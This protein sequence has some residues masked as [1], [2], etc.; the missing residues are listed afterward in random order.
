MVLN[1]DSFC[2]IN[3][4]ELFNFHFTKSSFLT[5][6]VVSR[7]SNE[8]YGNLLIDDSFEVIGYKEKQEKMENLYTNAGVYIFTKNALDLLPDK[9]K[10]SL[11]IDYFTLLPY[12]KPSYAYLLEN[13]FTDIGTPSNYKNF[14]YID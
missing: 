14:K 4:I 6:V 12:L 11:E 10:F 1:G 8:Q 5:F 13:D 7:D 9:N 3:F 2:E